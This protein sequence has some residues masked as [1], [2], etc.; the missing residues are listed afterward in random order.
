MTLLSIAGKI[1]ARVLL[2]RLNP[3]VAEE[4]LPG[5]QGGFSA[6]CGTTDMILV[7]RQVQK[8]WQEQNM[9]LYAVFLN[10]MKAFDTVSRK[11]VEK[12][13]LWKTFAKMGCIPHLISIL[14]LL[15]FHIGQKGHV[16]HSSMFS[17]SFP[18]ENSVKQG[19]VLGPTLFAIF[20]SMIPRRTCTRE[21]KY[22][23][24]P[25]GACS[26]CGGPYQDTR[27]IHP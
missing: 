5:S 25:M 3:V 19:C 23:F 9:V 6:N 7:L 24:A 10:L 14:I 21:S 4:V 27:R 1:L 8:K 11:P 26:T 16:K 17:D 13:Y 15:Q 18:I 12:A 22:G 2:D 20:F